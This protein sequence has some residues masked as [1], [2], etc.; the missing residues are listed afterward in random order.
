MTSQS[1]LLPV[2][3]PYAAMPTPAS[4]GLCSKAALERYGCVLGPDLPV[5][6]TDR[7][8]ARRREAGREREQRRA[9]L[10]LDLKLAARKAEKARAELRL[11]EADY[12]Q[13]W[14]SP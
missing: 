10:V 3:T 4:L 5:R 6:P 14:G 13:R 9:Q 11:E 8:R 1:P 7:E 12:W 2:P